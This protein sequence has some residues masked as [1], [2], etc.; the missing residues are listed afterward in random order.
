MKMIKYGLLAVAA[1][2]ILSGCSVEVSGSIADNCK[3]QQDRSATVAVDGTKTL[4]VIAGAGSL[5]IEGRPGLGEVRVRGTACAPSQSL[6]DRIDLRA[7]KV[8]DVVRVETILPSGS[9]GSS[10]TLDLTIEV[11]ESMVAR[12]DDASGEIQVLRIAG[13]EVEDSSGSMELVEIAGPIRISDDSGDIEVRDAGGN[14]VVK[15]DGSGSIRIDGVKGDVQIDRDSS[16]DID[17]TDVAGNVIIDEDG[18]GSIDVDTVQGDFTVRRDGS[19]G[20]QYR[21]VSGHTSVPKD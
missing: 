8:G 18:S 16:G 10:P 15:D 17:I 7:E 9:F 1:A 13:V 20:I 2:W 4:S 21:N 11:P 19:G 3:F 5:R 12:I 6:V 14:V